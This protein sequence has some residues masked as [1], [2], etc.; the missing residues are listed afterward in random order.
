MPNNYYDILGVDKNASEQEIKKAFRKLSLQ[1]HPDRN[2]DPEAETTFKTINEAHETLSDPEKRRQYD[3]QQQGIP[4]PGMGGG[5]PQEFHDM[6]DIF[7]QF[8]GGG[9][10]GM[11]GGVAFSM[12]GGMPGQQ[13]FHFFH[14]P[15]MGGSPGGFPGFFQNLQKPP[16]IIKTLHLTLEQ[17]YFGGNF[18]VQID[19][20]VVRNNIKENEIATIQ[21]GVPPGIDENEV[22]ILR[23]AGNTIENSIAGDVKIT[24]Q[25]T[26][27]PNFQRQGLDLVHNRSI[28]LKEA[29]CGFKFE[30][31]HLNNKTFSFNNH[32]NVTLIRP[33]YKKIIPGLGMNKNGQTGNLIINFDVNFP[34][35]LTDDQIKK[36]SEIL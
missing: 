7:R 14:G 15:G 10:P 3:M 16:P 1:Y 30:I 17:A 29:L 2:T 21:V 11:P 26:N 12:G 9:M 33:G 13:E 19:R 34:D 31:R 24:I 28:S 32:T 22:I 6:N 23:E 25:I 20:W 8:F 5:G 35:S 18:S 27:D 4:F 36:L